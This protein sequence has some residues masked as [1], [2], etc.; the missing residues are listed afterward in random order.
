MKTP[1]YILKEDYSYP[2]AKG[3]SHDLKILKAGAFVRP[4]Q[5]Q[6]VPKHVLEDE[7]WRWIMTKTETFAYT[8]Q[9]IVV[10]PLNIIRE[11]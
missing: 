7:R 3:N 11:V 10:I 5:I 2:S 9:G 8:S 6:Y 4:I 1:N